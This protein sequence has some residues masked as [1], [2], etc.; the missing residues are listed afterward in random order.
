MRIK[1]STPPPGQSS[2]LNSKRNSDFQISDFP[3]L[4]DL[5]HQILD[6]IEKEPTRDRQTN[7]DLSMNEVVFEVDRDGTRY[8]L[9]RSTPI[10][11]QGE[12]NLSPRE[13]VIVRLV[14]DG[15]T[16]KTIAAVLDISP[17]TVATHLR[18]VFTKLAVNS[19]AEMIARVLVDGL[20]DSRE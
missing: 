4:D 8:T 1:R 6:L 15:M 20:L 19:R 11:E 3:P 5:F 17:W 12:V 7:A 18:R 2:G 16:N 14:A 9:M 10:S 13:K